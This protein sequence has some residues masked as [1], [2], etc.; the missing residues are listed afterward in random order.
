V[1]VLSAKEY[2]RLVAAETLVDFLRCSSLAVAMAED[3]MVFV[4]MCRHNQLT[5]EQADALAAE[6]D[7]N[8]LEKLLSHL[9]E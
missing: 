3:E 5:E 7:R 9:L 1:V 4:D 2:V 8:V 6:I